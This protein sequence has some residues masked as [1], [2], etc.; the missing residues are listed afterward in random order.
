M[1]P[2]ME[3]STHAQTALEQIEKCTSCG[4][5]KDVC[6][7]FALTFREAESPRGKINLLRAVLDAKLESA[8]E[9][10]DVFNR[11]LLCY[12]CQDACPAGVS[13][14]KIWIS[15]RQTIADEAGI[16]LLKSLFLKQ[17]LTNSSLWK[18]ALKVGAK[19]PGGDTTIKLKGMRFPRPS[20]NRLDR[21]L[22]EVLEPRGKQVGRIAFF[23]GCMLTEVFPH[24]GLKAAEI[25][26]HLGYEV[27]TPQDRVCCGA[28]AFNN[29]DMDTGR[30]L[31]Q[32][33]LEVYSHMEVDA[34]ISPDAT[35]GGAFR[36]EYDILF[37][38][39]SI[40]HSEH[41]E[42]RKKVKDFGEF[43]L[44][45]FSKRS[46]VGF[47]PVENVVSVHDS[48]HLNH[49]QHKADVPRKLLSYIP[50]LKQVESPRNE[51][52]CGFGGSYSVIFPSESK[53]IARRK[54]DFMQS[55]GGKT[56]V[57][58]SPGCL[59]N[60]RT[61]AAELALDVSVVHYLE[62]VWYS[63]IGA[64]K[65]TKSPVSKESDSVAD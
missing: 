16:P 31:A 60:L 15:G 34:V 23:P 38:P 28:P 54:L 30:K 20:Q 18:T 41:R 40:G 55:S 13:T 51:L 21:I 43:L 2:E 36:H 14:E 46:D 12:A 48:C 25:L 52:C 6:P 4:L 27:I 47:K 33:N 42:F 26:A 9:T 24:I 37:P 1:A 45:V 56:F 58:G 29:G 59:W 8:P 10:A 44:Q 50:E 11:C 7:V 39:G 63:L 35:C 32:K 53:A 3:L 22:P 5:C 65:Q 57:V 61:E 17:F 62:L 64:A 49:L 19:L